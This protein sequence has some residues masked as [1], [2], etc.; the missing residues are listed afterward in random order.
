[1]VTAL[2][3]S[4]ALAGDVEKGKKLYKKCA[5]CHNA[6]SGAKHK[7]GPNLWGIYGAKA[8]IQ[9]GYKYSDWLKGAGIEWNDEALAAWISKKKEK[10][11]YF[12]KDVKKSKMIFA[13][14]K[15]PE[16][17]ADLI[18]YLKSLK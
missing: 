9:E 3:F 11:A 1:M 18:A 16:Q 12:G 14:L 2:N 8:A 7:T 17:I 10:A 6:A 4:G 13:G 15:K 5:A